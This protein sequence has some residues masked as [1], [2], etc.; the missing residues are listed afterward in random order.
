MKNKKIIGISITIAAFFLM[1]LLFFYDLF[2]G[3]EF[4]FGPV[5]VVASLICILLICCGLSLLFCKNPPHFLEVCTTKIVNLVEND[6][7]AISKKNILLFIGVLIIFSLMIVQFFSRGIKDVL[8]FPDYI[9]AGTPITTKQM[10]FALF[11][12]ILCLLISLFGR[13]N[14]RSKW[15]DLVICLGLLISA[16]Y[17]WSKLPLMTNFFTRAIDANSGLYY[18]FSDSRIYDLGTFSLLTGYGFGFKTPM[19]RPLY[20]L[21]LAILHLLYDNNFQQMMIAQVKF[22]ALIPVFAYLLGKKFG[23]R[24]VGGMTAALILFREY[25]QIILSSQT[26]LVSVQMMMSELFTELLLILLILFSFKWF[27]NLKS[28]NLALLTGMWF[29][30]SVL[31][32]GQIVILGVVYFLYFVILLAKKRKDVLVPFIFFLISFCA[33]VVPWMTR[34]YFANGSFTIDDPG[35][36]LNSLTGNGNN[37]I[38]GGPSTNASILSQ[39]LYRVIN[40]GAFYLRR[41]ISFMD[42][43]LVNSIFQLPFSVKLGNLE[44]YVFKEMSG[45]PIPF[46]HLSTSQFIY[47]AIQTIIIGLGITFAIRKFGIKGIFPFFIYLFYGLSGAILG[48]AGF[49]F[50]QPVDWI[51]LLYWSIGIFALILAILPFKLPSI[52]S[53]NKDNLFTRSKISPIVILIVLFSGLLIPVIDQIFPKTIHA[54]DKDRLSQVL[55]AMPKSTGMAE[56]T[57]YAKY[58]ILFTQNSD[59]D[60]YAN[61]GISPHSFYVERVKWDDQFISKEKTK[62]YPVLYLMLAKEDVRDVFMDSPV[63]STDLEN[64]YVFDNAEVFVYGC[65]QGD[66]IQAYYIQV[67]KDNVLYE[68]RSS[69]PAPEKCSQGN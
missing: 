35:Y 61:D 68:I 50:I 7:K 20:C 44:S 57:G 9:G 59:W 56:M 23:N 65:D 34:N 51:I 2:Q 19:Q 60:M 37:S 46:I 55:M 64:G 63:L 49:R 6:R 27:S 18:P 29:G 28:K 38:G 31:N 66:H 30:L 17:L 40:S 48:Y 5:K 16:G 21:F 54:P 52:N 4:S 24:A 13:S 8:D 69:I 3:H 12:G 41:S 32:R 1:V 14:W 67:K 43:N 22:F 33:V 58:P 15:I 26:T 36:F 47:L 45:F 62:D 42:Y 10:L 53:D 11:F 25:N 39:I